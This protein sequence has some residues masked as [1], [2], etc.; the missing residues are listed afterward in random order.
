M[1]SDSVALVGA[2]EATISAHR[3]L[4]DAARAFAIAHRTHHAL[5]VEPLSWM[6]Q[7]PPSGDGDGR[8]WEVR[9]GVPGEP[10]GGV[11]VFGTLDLGEAGERGAGGPFLS[12]EYLRFGDLP[13]SR[14]AESLRAAN[15]LAI[16]ADQRLCD[17]VRVL[18]CLLPRD[19]LPAT[20]GMAVRDIG[21][22]VQMPPSGDGS[23]RSW[24]ATPT[25]LHTGEPGVT[26]S[27]YDEGPHADPRAPLV[28]MAIM[29]LDAW[30]ATGSAPV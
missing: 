10:D 30:G 7:M 4:H 28:G 23:G 20:F 16:M 29:P 19:Q 21:W 25:V 14:E 9:P 24:T 26:L 22:V 27:F 2:R 12:L 17:V 18:T 11:A 15:A 1:S 6:A 3:R 13:D 5:Q 8:S